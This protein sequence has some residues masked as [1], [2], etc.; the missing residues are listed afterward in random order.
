MFR[1]NWTLGAPVP[2]SDRA[3]LGP[4]HGD[5]PGGGSASGSL[6]STVWSHSSTV[7]TLAPIGHREPCE[8]DPSSH[9]SQR[10]LWRGPQLG[11]PPR[12]HGQMED[13]MGN[14]ANFLLPVLALHPLFLSPSFSLSLSFLCFL[15]LSKCFS[16]L[17][18][19]LFTYHNTLYFSGNISL[20]L[21]LSL[22]LSASP[23][24]SP[25]TCLSHYLCL[26]RS[27]FSLS[28]S[29]HHL[30]ADHERCKFEINVFWN[31][32]DSVQQWVRLHSSQCSE[33]GQAWRGIEREAAERQHKKKIFFSLVFLLVLEEF[34]HVS[35]LLACFSSLYL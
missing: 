8:G 25:I 3:M 2:E 31:E 12:N 16:L 7:M 5:E 24:L 29:P 15:S 9:W 14:R 13:L 11:R 26:S 23:S 18:F 10:A 28:L 20:S 30:W 17:Y 33:R 35:F 1:L 6:R 34:Y 32:P 4:N 27:F 22:Y 21:S 19:L